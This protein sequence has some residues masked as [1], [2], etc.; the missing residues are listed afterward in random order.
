MRGLYIIIAGILC[1]TIASCTIGSKK[2]VSDSHNT[3]SSIAGYKWVLIELNGKKAKE[4][5][6]MKKMPYIKFGADSTISGNG[7]CNGYGG[8]Y[9]LNGASG[10]E[11]S[12]VMSTLIACPDNY[13]QTQEV[14]LFK[15][16]REAHHYGIEQNILTIYNADESSFARFKAQK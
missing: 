11:I 7:G 14:G 1:V 6:Q 9:V 3:I 5:K 2:T 8:K 10:I 12:D 15:L 13:V 16:Y 4:D